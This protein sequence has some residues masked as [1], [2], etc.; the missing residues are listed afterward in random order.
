VRTPW[1]GAPGAGPLVLGGAVITPLAAAAEGRNDAARVLRVDFGL[2]SLLLA[3]DIEAAGEQALVASGAPLGAAV[4]KV[5]HHGSRTSSGAALLS[6]VRPSIALVSVGARNVYG[7]PD[8]GV[9]ARLIAAGADLYRTDRDGAL[10]LETDGRT[11]I[12][13][14]WATRS[15]VRYCLDPDTFC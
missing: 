12:L 14:R 8:A 9:L 2:V 11:L 5:P 1:D 10:L 13:T 7:H 15:T 4:L 6:A 3:S